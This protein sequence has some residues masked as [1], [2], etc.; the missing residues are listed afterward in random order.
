[1]SG[2]DSSGTLRDIRTLY[3][4]GVVGTL[5]DKQL[6]ERFVNRSD[7]SAEAAFTIL[8]ERHGP[9]VWGVCRRLLADRHAAADAFQATFLVLLRRAP[10]VRVEDS[11][12]RWLYGVS[13]RVAGRARAT[14]LR[15]AARET[16]DVE[17]VAG[18]GPDPCGAERLA[19]LDEEIGRLPEHYREA[20]VLCD[21]E[22]LPHEEAARRLGCPVGTVESRLSRG[23]QRLRER[24]V[25]RGLAPA[26]VALWSATAREASAT[27][28]AALIKQ[29]ARFVMCSQA[30][31]AVPT[32]VATL[33]EGVLQMI[34]FARVKPLVAATTALVLATA[35]VGVLGQ[36]R[37]APKGAGTPA[38]TEPR[39]TAGPAVPQPLDMDA[40]SAEVSSAYGKAEPEVQEFVLH[41][42]RSF[43]RSGLWLN[44]KAYAALKPADREAKVTYL[45]K[46]FENPEYG[47]HLCLALAEASA[48]K[49]PRLVPGLKRVACYHVEGKDYDCRPKWMAIAALARQES[50][51]A[52]PLLVS[53]VDHGNQ[54]TRFWARAA[55]ARMAKND[56]KTDKQAWN[57]WWVGQGHEPIEPALLKPYT[58]PV[59]EK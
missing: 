35:T 23:R 26:A 30:A 59:A 45:V 8:L 56:F 44:E 40:A 11:L 46:L 34:G 57:K 31:G 18:P 21:L 22:G 42:A 25:R 55:L 48:L 3:G 29:T 47:R 20:V 9:M 37:T 10:A 28:P 52:V 24:L 41:T 13:R 12:G 19:V 4:D 32:A 43:G 49:D 2:G 39:P 14:S 36:Q 50:P 33:A 7:A 54:N 17:A 16:G 1:M 58:P 38:K 27:M 5:S 6:L 15:R 51:Q 53:L